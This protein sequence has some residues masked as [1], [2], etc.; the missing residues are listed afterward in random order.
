MYQHHLNLVSA[1][2]VDFAVGDEMKVGITQVG[3]TVAGV[4][5]KASMVYNNCPCF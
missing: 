2:Y 3:S 5:L 4:G 1:G